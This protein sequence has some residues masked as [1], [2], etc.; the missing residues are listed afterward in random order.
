MQFIVHKYKLLHCVPYP[1]KLSGGYANQGHI[2]F[3]FIHS[4]T[5]ASFIS[6]YIFFVMEGESWR[7]NKSL[8]P[9]TGNTAFKIYFRDWKQDWNVIQYVGSVLMKYP[10]ILQKNWFIAFCKNN[11]NPH[12]FKNHSFWPS[13]NVKKKK[14]CR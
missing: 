5:Q 3:Y 13:F 6:A 14:I 8:Q 12:C 10:H 9:I 2:S 1:C 11:R 4:S 7:N